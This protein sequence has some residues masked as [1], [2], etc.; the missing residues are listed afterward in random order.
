MKK[1]ADDRSFLPSV[2]CFFHQL[3][4]FECIAAVVNIAIQQF[5]CSIVT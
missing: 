2:C 3:L 5:E 1:F 4:K